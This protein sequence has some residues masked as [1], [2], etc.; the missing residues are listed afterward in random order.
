M[1]TI[2]C[3]TNQSSYPKILLTLRLIIYGHGDRRS[4]FLANKD[5]VFPAT[6]LC[7]KNISFLE[8]LSVRARSD[9]QSFFGK[10]QLSQK[11]WQSICVQIQQRKILQTL[12]K[13]LCLCFFVCFAGLAKGR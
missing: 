8:K 9:E 5:L 10:D 7:N 1:E 6:D 11:L 3:H 4:Y 12:S 13:N 2:S